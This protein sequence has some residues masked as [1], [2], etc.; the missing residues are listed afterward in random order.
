ME[1]VTQFCGQKMVILNIA[2]VQTFYL[3]FVDLG[4][5]NALVV[6]WEHGLCYRL[7]VLPYI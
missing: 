2:G 3:L 5:Y 1:V 7:F 6:Y 4:I